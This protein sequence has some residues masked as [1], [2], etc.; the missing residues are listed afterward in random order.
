MK[1]RETF[2]CV[3]MKAE[4]QD[5]LM[6][7]YD[8]MNAADSRITQRDCIEKDPLLGPFLREVAT[9]WTDSVPSRPS[10]RRR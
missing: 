1:D 9:S 5:H 3:Q 4:I 2:D 8:G 6:R 7:E 10:S